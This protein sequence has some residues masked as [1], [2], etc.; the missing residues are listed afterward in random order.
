MRSEVGQA[1][2]EVRV[3]LA[4]VAADIMPDKCRLIVGE[5]EYRDTPCKL[6]GGSGNM[7]GASYR[8]RFGWGSPAVIGAAAVVDA[9]PGRQQLTLQLVEPADST[10]GIWQEWQA[11]S[12]P[13]FGRVN[14]G[15]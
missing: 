11:T 4:E 2:D 6:I 10:T 3:A 13:A 1:Y 14:V 8:I 15:L 9:I 12:G 7:D 5:K